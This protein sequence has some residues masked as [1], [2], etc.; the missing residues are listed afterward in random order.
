MMTFWIY[1]CHWKRLAVCVSCLAIKTNFT[2]SG[3]AK[4]EAYLA[5]KK[6]SSSP[7]LSKKFAELEEFYNKKWVS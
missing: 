7:E 2:M 6:E 1:S 4:V 5:S 3:N